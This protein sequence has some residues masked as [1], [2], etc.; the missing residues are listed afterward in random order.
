VKAIGATGK[1]IFFA[2]SLAYPFAQVAAHWR[3]SS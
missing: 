1:S 3:S 2:T